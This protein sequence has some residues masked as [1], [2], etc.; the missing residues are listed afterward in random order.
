MSAQRAPIEL[1]ELDQSPAETAAT[2]PKE[3]DLRVGQNLRNAR[4]LRGLTQ[5]QLGEAVD[6]TLQQIQK[7][8]NGSNRITVSRLHQFSE[9]LNV[10]VAQFFSGPATNAGVDDDETDGLKFSADDFEM[11]TLS[12][13]LSSRMKRRLICLIE[14]MAEPA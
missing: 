4:N 10:P 12:H 13:R 2:P 8:E 1:I 6:L 14:E 11:L 9:I 7:Y 5:R 3:V